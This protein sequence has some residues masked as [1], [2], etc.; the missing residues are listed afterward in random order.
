MFVNKNLFYILTL[1]VFAFF[2]SN[3]SKAETGYV[4]L[5]YGISTHDI[6]ATTTIGKMT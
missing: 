5:N 6:N 2:V 1:L 3:I 4:K